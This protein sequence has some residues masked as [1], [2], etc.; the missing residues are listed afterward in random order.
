MVLLGSVST[1]YENT[2]VVRRWRCETASARWFAARGCPGSA[3]RACRMMDTFVPALMLL[4]VAALE[5]SRSGGVPMW[6]S[7]IMPVRIR[8]RI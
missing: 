3:A 4:L 1:R 2:L 8:H 7:V 6:R 5:L